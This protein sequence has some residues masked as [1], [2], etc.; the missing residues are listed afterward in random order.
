[1]TNRLL[2]IPLASLMLGALFGALLWAPVRGAE[3]RARLGSGDLK[4]AAT[5]AGATSDGAT[6]DAASER[7]VAIGDIHG[8]FANFTAILRQ[9]GTVDAKNR[10]AAQNVTVVQTGDA[11]DRSA[12]SRAVLDLLMELEKQAGK[13]KSKLI[14][15][16]GNHEMMNITG[17]LRYVTPEEYATFSDSKSEKRR[18]SAW[19]QF[20]DWSRARAKSLGKPEPVLAEAPD[21]AW[22]EA[23]PLGY[24]EHR[25]AFGPSG[26]YG[27]WLRRRDAVAQV[28]RTLFLHGG[29]SPVLPVATVAEANQRIRDELKL[30]DDYV[31]YFSE[32]RLA[33]PFFT[34]AELAGAVRE[35]LDARKTAI[36][37]KTAQAVAEGKT[38]EAPDDEKRQI[39][40]FEQ[41]LEFPAWHSINPEGPLWYRGY[42]RWTDAEGQPL[43]EQIL[44]K[45][46]ATAVVVGHSPLAD[47]RIKARFGGRIFLIDT[48]MLTSYYQGGRPSALEINA[49]TFTA[50]YLDQRIVV[51]PVPS[52]Q[53][54][55]SQP[56]RQ[57]RR[58]LRYHDGE[59]EFEPGGGL[60]LSD[61][62]Q[63]KAAKAKAP[64]NSATKSP[65]RVPWMG[66]EGQPLPFK[67][68]SDAEEFLRTAKVVSA[69]DVGSGI[70]R[71]KKVLLEKDGV[72]MHAIFRKVNEDKQEALLA[73]G[74]KI[75]DFRDSYVFEVAA[76][77]L[78]KMLGIENIPPAVERSVNG[79]AGSLQ[80]WIENAMSEID[81]QKKKI[82]PPDVHAW[83]HQLQTM[84]LFD[85]L[86][87][88]WD[89]HMNNILIDPQWRLW[90][91]DHTR[92][93]RRE[94]DT[95][96]LDQVILCDRT[97]W[98]RLRDLDDK[99]IRDRLGDYLRPGELDALLERRE[100]I[101]AYL[102]G[103]IAT[104]GA[105]TVLFSQ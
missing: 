54:A 61:P 75:R 98:Q 5:A 12:G 84:R 56:L 74:R 78:A 36:A 8:D 15:L 23:H 105:Q 68:A 17:D 18:Q 83:N 49:G 79:D 14:P 52:P 87:Y 92:S 59:H 58:Q 62:E 11:I 30:F 26:K 35:E 104:R 42:A 89:R 65:A 31:R 2:R 81:R 21:A 90:M 38:Y 3:P 40:I 100:Q 63:Q 43:A 9:A 72:R 51:H 91:V 20:A 102:K 77:E 6:S 27:K 69:R 50:I 39:T 76:Y 73:T 4:V 88:N 67:S 64:G 37:A 103:I 16:L 95:P 86:I 60:P 46:G 1:M 80:V 13:K 55:Q 57:A 94:L 48:G 22:L 44:A 33:L 66:P 71:P 7:V 53:P 29:I 24:F 28:G 47:G 45:F 101:V 10:W 25:E 97:V 41:F 93:F 34:L 70:T 19:K 82:K 99:A 96:Y 85:L 32:Q